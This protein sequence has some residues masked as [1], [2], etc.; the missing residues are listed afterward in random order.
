MLFFLEVFYYIV[1]KL[2]DFFC[3][4]LSLMVAFFVQIIVVKVRI[5][6]VYKSGQPITKKQTLKKPTFYLV[7]LNKTFKEGPSDLAKSGISFACR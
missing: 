4:V 1:N 6:I 2:W 3:K 7:K 5:Q